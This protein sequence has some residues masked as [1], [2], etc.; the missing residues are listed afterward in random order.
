[1]DRPNLPL[2]ALRAFEA[3]ARHLNFTR[4][5]L[6]LCVSQGAVSHQV[7]ALERRLG[8]RLFRRLPRGLALTD[9]GRALVPVLAEAFD[10]IG[11]TL[12]R[13]A[14][15]HLTEV[16]TVGVVGTF[17][18]GWLLPRLEDF[19]RAHPHIDL[20]VLTNNNRV[21][22]AGEGLD[23]AI[24]FGDGAWHG[25]QADPI[26]DAPLSPLCAPAVAARLDRPEA[27]G[28]EM[29]LRSYR[30][31]E[32]PR[33]FAAARLPCPPLR[34]PLFDSSV[35]MVAAA[36]AQGQGVAL[37]PPALFAAE[38]AAGRI[39]QPFAITVTTGR[40]W[41]TRLHSRAETAA[42]RAFREWVSAS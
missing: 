31:D 7:A 19:A 15:G 9:E 6:E 22:L 24:R 26:L 21:D 40:Y 4:A 25:T 14:G 16:L 30:A 34:G 8:T 35:L 20:R 11:A 36:A 1:M 37:A 18:V 3:S 42:M 39:V 28:G 41:L 10:R 2:N 32:W 33:W 12:D 5:A 13:Y 17:A 29:L 38:L 27:L 23:L